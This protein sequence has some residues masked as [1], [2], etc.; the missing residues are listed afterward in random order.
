ME[1]E[2]VIEGRRYSVLPR[3]KLACDGK[4]FID[5]SHGAAATFELLAPGGYGGCGIAISLM[6][7]EIVRKEGGSNAYK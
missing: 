5:L 4:H 1:N 6:V 2:I 3:Y 7:K